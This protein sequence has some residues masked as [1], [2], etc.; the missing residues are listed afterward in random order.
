MPSADD[1]LAH[2]NAMFAKK[3]SYYISK[4]PFTINQKFSS[5]ANDHLDISTSND[6]LFRIYSWDT[7]TGGT[8]HFFENVMQYKSGSNFKAFIDTTK[9][10]GG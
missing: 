7:W 6:G 8:M 3:L 2:A 1:S 10:G 4:C 9:S 5:L